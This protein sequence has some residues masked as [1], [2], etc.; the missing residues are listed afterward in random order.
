MRTVASSSPGAHDVFLRAMGMLD[1]G[2][3]DDDNGDDDSQSIML[4]DQCVGFLV[5][6]PWIE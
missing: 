1:D 6:E 5:F 2:G 4:F 3:L